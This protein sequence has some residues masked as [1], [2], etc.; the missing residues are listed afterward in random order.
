MITSLLQVTK[1][2]FME[3]YAGVS[4]SID[5]DVYFDYMMRQAWNI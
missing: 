1:D 5:K 3:Y 2:E 4:A